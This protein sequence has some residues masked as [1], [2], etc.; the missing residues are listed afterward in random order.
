MKCKACEHYEN[1]DICD[2]ECG[3]GVNGKYFERNKCFES[4]IRKNM[5]DA[6][7]VWN[8]DFC[9]EN[10]N[11]KEQSN[12]IKT[13]YLCRDVMGNRGWVDETETNDEESSCLAD[14]ETFD[15]NDCAHLKAGI[16]K[17]DCKLYKKYKIGHRKTIRR[18]E[19]RE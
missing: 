7:C 18:K 13:I 15:I 1:D 19:D 12:E 17:E 3:R 9:K 10:K 16:K 2:N 5:N 4:K 8:C 14:L 6:T 11:N